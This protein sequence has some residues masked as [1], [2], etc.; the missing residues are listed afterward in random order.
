[1]AP[2][3]K[4]PTARSILRR[5]PSIS[6]AGAARRA[7]IAVPTLRMATMRAESLAQMS[8]LSGW[9]LHVPNF[10][11][12]S[13][14]ARMPLIALQEVVSGR[15]SMLVNRS[16]NAGQPDAPRNGGFRKITAT[17]ISFHA[18]TTTMTIFFSQPSCI[19]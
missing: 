7:P 11:L 5:R 12:N 3:Q 8:S 10:S 16:A 6:P 1:M 19:A 9:F 14:M 17:H 13:F 15:C 2:I 18:T 4:M